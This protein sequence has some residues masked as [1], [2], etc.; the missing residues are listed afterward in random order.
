VTA[1]V[2]RATRAVRG[3][4][5]SHPGETVAAFSHAVTIRAILADALAMPVASMFR[6]DQAHGGISV[7]EWHDGTP[8]VRLVNASSIAA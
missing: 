8:Y 3:L 1:L 2:E 7:V 4:A 5:E 6:L